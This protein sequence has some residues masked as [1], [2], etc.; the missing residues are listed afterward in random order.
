[1][2]QQLHPDQ[3]IP[4]AQEP[5]AP[6]WE[7][8]LTMMQQMGQVQVNNNHLLQQI[9]LANNIGA[10]A[11]GAAAPAPAPLP[12][13]GPIEIHP[14]NPRLAKIKEPSTFTGKVSDVISFISEMRQRFDY[15]PA[16]Y[17][18]D[19]HKCMYFGSYLGSG[20]PKQWYQGSCEADPTF[21]HN[22]DAF[23]DAFKRHFGDSDLQGT[24]RRQLQALRQI[25]STST[26]AARFREL[27]V[28]LELTEQS[29]VEVFWAG[30]KEQVRYGLAIAG[31]PDTINE[32]ITRAIKLDNDLHQHQIETTRKKPNHHSA[33][34]DSASKSTQS[35]S[36]TT[37]TTHASNQVV[38]MDIDAIRTAP[39]G[40]ITPVERQRRIDNRLCLYCGEEGHMVS[41]C[42]KSKTPFKPRPR[43]DN[44]EAR[45]S[46][47]VEDKKGASS[48]TGKAE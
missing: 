41:V 6:T 24:V 15:N 30:L 2:D 25:G 45:I 40:P 17:P 33:S 29:K 9:L 32:L 11:P 22:F 42:P 34:R 16:S 48:S 4:Q 21:L 37:T 19:L 44:R 39:R 1:M 14:A 13:P 38:P 10:N 8:L 5:V 27:I 12:V 20:A 31:K 43:T 36:Q 3:D 47:A 26:Y 18:T 46:A 23:V 7:N 28:H 35:T